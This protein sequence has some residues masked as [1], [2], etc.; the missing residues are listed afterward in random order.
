MKQLFSSTF[1]RIDI[2][3][4]FKQYCPTPLQE[5]QQVSRYPRLSPQHLVRQVGS[6][7]VTSCIFQYFK[8]EC[9]KIHTVP[10]KLSGAHSL[11]HPQKKNISWCV[12]SQPHN[13]RVITKGHGLI[14]QVKGKL[15]LIKLLNV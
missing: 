3:E 1:W 6:R 2:W 13:F 9:C 5:S 12:S 10:S 11:L 4:S 15:D 8:A 7:R 14:E